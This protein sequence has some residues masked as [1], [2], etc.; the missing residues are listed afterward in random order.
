MHVEF[1]ILSHF[2]VPL[3]TQSNRLAS[4]DFDKLPERGAFVCRIKRLPLPPSNYRLNYL[5][6]SNMDY[7]LLDALDHA[8]DMNV[9]GADFFSSGELPPAQ[10]GCCYV[11]GDWQVVPG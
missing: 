11:D 1:F 7:E 4:K 9:E 5:V 8:V 2:E 6:R 3:F 10:L